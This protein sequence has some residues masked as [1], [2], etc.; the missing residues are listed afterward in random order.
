MYTLNWLPIGGFVKLEGEDGDNANDPRAFSR[1][2]LPV[3]LGILVAGRRDEPPAGVR[4]LH[5][6]RAVGRAADRRAGSARSSPGRR[7][8]RAASSPATRSSPSTARAT[9]RSRNPAAG[10]R[11]PPGERRP[12]RHARDPPRR[13]HASSDVAVVAADADA[14]AAGRARDPGVGR[15][16]RGQDRQH[17][18]RGGPDRRQAH[19]PGVQP[20]PGRAGRPRPLDRHRPDAGAAGVRSGR[21]RGRAGQRPV[22]PRAAVRDLPH[23]RCCRPTS[24]S[25]TSSRSRRSTAAGCW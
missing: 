10:D 15:V 20:D 5:R 11:R 22:G 18:R 3:K 6:A 19:G 17:V 9:P 21:D 12:G 4:D 16:D 8:R 24:P 7:R 23:R 13:R 2:R 14:G 1:A 25:S